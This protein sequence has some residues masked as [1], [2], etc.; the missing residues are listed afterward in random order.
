MT[1]GNIKILTTAVPANKTQNTM[2]N[3]FPVKL[4]TFAVVHNI[5]LVFFMGDYPASG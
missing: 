2:N 3:M 5:A 1:N 4:Q